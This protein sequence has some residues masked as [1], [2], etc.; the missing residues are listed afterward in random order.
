MLKIKESRYLNKLK[1]LGFK[2]KYNEDTG[3]IYKYVYRYE[4]CGTSKVAVEVE[5]RVYQQGQYDN[6]EYWR[7][8][9]IEFE[10]LEKIYDLIQ[11]GLVEKV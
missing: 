7:I 3:E 11:A 4:F 1:E 9:L 5:Q 10:G 6:V 8:G 2:P